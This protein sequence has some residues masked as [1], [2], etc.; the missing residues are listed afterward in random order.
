MV[1]SGFSLPESGFTRFY[2]W[3]DLL[4][5]LLIQLIYLIDVIF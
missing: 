4:S 3:Q 5:E 1:Y 2:D